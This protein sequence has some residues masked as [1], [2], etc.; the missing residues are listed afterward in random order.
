MKIKNANQEFKIYRPVVVSVTF[1]T[2]Q[3]YD[4]FFRL[5]SWNETG[6]ELLASIGDTCDK[7]PSKKEIKE[8]FTMMHREMQEGAR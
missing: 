2:Q 1:E 6:P 7:I 8:F 5:F 3:E 4:K